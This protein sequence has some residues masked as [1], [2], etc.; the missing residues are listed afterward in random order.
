M[1]RS[2]GPTDY[3]LI[4]KKI[5]VMKP[6]AEGLQ[7]VF[8]GRPG[9]GKTTLACT[10]P[11]PLL[12]IDVKE[13]GTDSVHDVPGV[14]VLRPMEWGD[15]DRAYWYIRK[16]PNKFKSCVW[17]TV[18][19]GQDFAIEDIK[20]EQDVGDLGK[21]GTLT[22]KDWGQV[23]SMLKTTIMDFRDLGI[24]FVFIA[25]D[26]VFGAEDE[27]DE[28]ITPQMG[29]RLMPSVAST[30][31]AAVGV[32]GNTFIRE[33]FRE[34]RIGKMKKRV[35]K[36][37]YCLRVGPHSYYVTKIR[38]PRRIETPAFII[39]PTYEKIANAIKGKVD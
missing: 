27:D 13:R 29:P 34:I 21:W 4:E 19:Q 16:N 6:M 20:G 15:F 11:K 5:H 7:A 3:R 30:L 12:L 8:Y 36:V 24:N 39:D 18:S 31:N 9:T 25:H 2:R 14:K 33:T 26:R 38:K 37:E 35:R 32:I 10:F 1:K 28:A 23:S 17:D 22:K